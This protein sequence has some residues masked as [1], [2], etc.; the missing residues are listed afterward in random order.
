MHLFMPNA[1]AELHDEDELM[2]NHYISVTC[3]MSY[4]EMKYGYRLC[5]NT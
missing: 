3:K 5:P 2:R 4:S 1:K